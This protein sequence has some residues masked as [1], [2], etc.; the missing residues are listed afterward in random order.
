MFNVKNYG[1]QGNGVAD[2]TVPIRNALAAAEA[3]GGGIIYLP[4]GTYD[5]CPQASDL[6]SRLYYDSPNYGSN[7]PIFVITTSNIVF[8]G[9]G[10]GKTHLE[11][12]S[13]GMK[14]PVTNWYSATPGGA[15]VRFD[16]FMVYAS[17]AIST[18]EFRSLDI[19]GNAGWTPDG[20]NGS[21]PANPITGDGWDI[22]NKGIA[23]LGATINN[24]LVFNCT[25]HDFRGE[26]VYA[27]GD[28]PG[29]I[30]II[31]TAI[32]S[33]NG[34]AVSCSADVLMSHDTIGGTGAGMDVY[35][36]VENFDLGA[37]E[38]TV[39]EDCSISCSSSA[40]SVHG[41]G[42][43][44]LGL[45][46]SSLT[47]TNTTLTNNNFGIL[48]SE[49]GYNVTVQGNTFAND[50]AGMIDSILG[51]Y[52]TY[53]TYEGFGDFTI[54]DNTFND[55]ANAFVSQAYAGDVPR[56]PPFDNLVIED[57]TVANGTLL[58]GAFWSATPN[59]WTGFV[60]SNNVLDA[61]AADLNN[62]QFG[63]NFAIWTNTT[64]QGANGKYTIYDYSKET[65]TTLT[66]S[67]QPW[68]GVF[69]PSSDQTVVGFNQNAG[70]TQYIEL[71][72]TSLAGYPPGFQ[73][74]FV[75]G[76]S[77]PGNWVL[78]ADPAWNNFANNEPIA[79]DGLWVGV[80]A[81]GL[82]TL[83]PVLSNSNAILGNAPVAYNAGSPAAPV[84]PS[85]SVAD[86]TSS[87]LAGAT[88]QISEGYQSGEDLLSFANTATITGS[89]NAATGTLTLTGLDSVADYQD[90][91]Q[92]VTFVDT[93]ATPT[94]VR[95]Q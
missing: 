19:S 88:V 28:D 53:A 74:E 75:N 77:S 10:S 60:V 3:A 15:V 67:E 92:A 48:F 14:N 11:G 66:A 78:K 47:V 25:M 64:R 45:P 82:F 69:L 54:S 32:Y 50:S 94:F 51:L 79:P 21:W 30:S 81:Q 62:Y 7:L 36:G 20:V 27:G 95:G 71:D 57:N 55:C 84:F 26:V 40:A 91:L 58:G 83:I 49:F 59:S 87:T 73:T 61:N 42:I 29:Q 9:D 22:T 85:I 5:V 37:P 33:S 46:S 65:T 41:N 23:M 56:S 38:K 93:S 12:Y 16:M 63:N 86:P 43:V 17:A 6:T 52:P 31:N 2:D 70:T 44:Y 34:D 13:L 8:I 76:P 39:I 24:V 72:A 4:A 90:A 35:N 68:L 89:W 1:A 80:N 18:I